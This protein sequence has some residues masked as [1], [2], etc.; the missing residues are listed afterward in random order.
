M[1]QWAWAMLGGATRS[2]ASK[3]RSTSEGEVERACIKYHSCAPIELDAAMSS[4]LH[5]GGGPSAAAA[6][7]RRRRHEYAAH[8]SA[9]RPTVRVP[10]AAAETRRPGRVEGTR[11]AADLCGQA[12]RAP[13]TQRRCDR[14]RGQPE[15]ESR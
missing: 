5:P 6:Q 10:V 14:P 2:K 8:A 9:G 15:R 7:V 4:S 12:R 13:R 1:S 11:P 3:T